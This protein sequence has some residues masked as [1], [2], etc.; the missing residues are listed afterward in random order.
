MKYRKPQI[1]LQFPGHEKELN[2]LPEVEG[3]KVTSEKLKLH[4]K[5]MGSKII[6]S[7]WSRNPN[8][9]YQPKNRYDTK[10]TCQFSR[11]SNIPR[12]TLLPPDSRKK[13]IPQRISIKSKFKTVSRNEP[14]KQGRVFSRQNRFRP[15]DLGRIE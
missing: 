12:R 1:K 2:H 6:P 9:R 5:G 10:E 7:K 14:A 11:N 15:Q 3:E 8:P 4:V 13:E